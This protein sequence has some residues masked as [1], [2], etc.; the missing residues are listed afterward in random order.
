MA[1]ETKGVLRDLGSRI[2]EL[3]RAQGLTQEELSERLGMLAPNYARIEQGRMNTTVETLVRIAKAL[4]V[5][6]AD[7]FAKP[8][9]KK[10]SVGRPR[11]S[12]E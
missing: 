1:G 8:K 2:R 6:V 9:T 4:K 5:G 11:K 7:L 12:D 3:R 10:A